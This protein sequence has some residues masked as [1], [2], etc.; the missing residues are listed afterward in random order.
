M[1][2]RNKGENKLKTYDIAK[3][4]K[5]QQITHHNIENQR[6]KTKEEIFKNHISSTVSTTFWKISLKS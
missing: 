1:Q 6:L 3:K 5:D 2:V 4:E